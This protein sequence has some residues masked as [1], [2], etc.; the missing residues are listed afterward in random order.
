MALGGQGAPLACAFHKARFHSTKED[1]A[2]INIGGIANI[3]YLPAGLDQPVVGFDTGPGNSLYDHWIR[4]HLNQAYDENGDWA[5]GGQIIDDLLNQ[6]ISNEEYFRQSLPKTTGTEYFNS[7]WL[8]PY[9]DNDQDAR[10]IQTTLVEL[11]AITIS[12]ALE[13]LP[14]IPGNCYICGG[15][16]HNSYLVDRISHA[17]PDSNIQTTAA[18]GIDPDYVEAIAF[19]WLAQQRVELRSGNLP[20]VTYASSYSILGG[21]YAAD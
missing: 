15:G 12:G 3:T 7:E 5:R 10:D 8:A 6:M 11:T 13:G 16:A 18:L 2:V 9:L 21:I 14:S 4:E 1:R 17:A 20:D 19:A